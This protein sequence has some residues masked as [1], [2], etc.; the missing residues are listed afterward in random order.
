MCAS[1]CC[2]PRCLL[3]SPAQAPYRNPE[4]VAWRVLAP[5]VDILDRNLHRAGAPTARRTQPPRRQPTASGQGVD[6]VLVVHPH[7]SVLDARVAPSTDALR[8]ASRRE[9]APGNTTTLLASS[10]C[11]CADVLVPTTPLRTT[12]VRAAMLEVG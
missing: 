10:M 3:L 11:P 5:I 9:T 6:E 1:A 7:L 12:T 4:R 2:P 8:M